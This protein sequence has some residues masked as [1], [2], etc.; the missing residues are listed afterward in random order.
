MERNAESIKSRLLNEIRLS[1][2][3]LQDLAASQAIPLKKLAYLLAF[4]AIAFFDYFIITCNFYYCSCERVDH[5]LYV[6]E[7]VFLHE[8][9]DYQS[10]RVLVF[11]FCPM[12]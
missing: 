4:R 6:L 7:A 12:R 9:K 2:R 10:N 5:L 8:L 3:D 11:P 1:V